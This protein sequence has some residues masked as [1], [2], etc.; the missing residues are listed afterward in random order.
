VKIV[1]VTLT[2]FRWEGIPPVSYGVNIRLPGGTSVLGLLAIITD[3]GVIGHAFLGGATRDAEI[4]GPALIKS[5]KPLLMG[6]NPLDR[7]KLHQRLWGRG[8]LT[9]VRAIGAVD[10]AL[11]DLAGKIANLP[12]HRLLGSYRDRI[13]AYASSQVLESTRQYREQA[14]E[15]RSRGWQAYKIHPPHHSWQGDIEVCQ[16]VRKAVGTGYPLMLDATWSYDYPTAVRVGRAIE[17]LDFHWFEDPL[18][19]WNIHGYQKLRQQ[20][21][22]PLMA[23]E[24]PFGG[25]DQYVPWLLGQATDF[26]RGDVYFKGGITT[27]IKAA[28]VAEAF[29]MNFEIHHGCNSLNNVACLHVALA[30]RNCEYFEVLL[31]DAANKYGLVQDIEVDSKGW[32]RAPTGPGLGVEI[33]FELIRR[34]TETVLA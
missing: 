26:L 1:D 13:P 21:H 31:P 32:V 8:R 12:I 20:L 22:I 19:E 18:G 7:E 23:T 2:L 29:G 34:N 14:L 30:I 16:A 25:L 3:E 4:E 10:V 28:H 17:E 33:D 6:E 24:L 27:C 15:Y 9:Q 5:L 11:W